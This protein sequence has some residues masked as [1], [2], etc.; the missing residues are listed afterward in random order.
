VEKNDRS[1]LI[2]AVFWFITVC[3]VTTCTP[4]G[5]TAAMARW[6]AGLLAPGA[7]TTLMSSNWPGSWATACAVGSVNAARLAPARLPADPN[8][9]MPVMVNVRIAPADKIR[10][11]CPTAKPYLLAVPASITTSS[12]VTGGPP[13]I[14]RRLD[15]CGS[16]SKL[17]PRV[18]ALLFAIGLP[19]RATNWA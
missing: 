19:S 17:M 6:T 12:E 4:A 2:A 3:P 5:R 9:A 18:G 7:V 15:I 16:G 1:W 14:M 11:R 10:T 8:S 13:A